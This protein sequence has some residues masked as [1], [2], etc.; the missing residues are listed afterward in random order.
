MVE[1]N[2]NVND[3]VRYD[4]IGLYDRYGIMRYFPLQGPS[5][6][7]LWL[8]FDGRIGY[9]PVG[10]TNGSAWDVPISDIEN[11]SRVGSE[12]L[13]WCPQARASCSL[14]ANFA[15]KRRLI[16]FTGIAKFMSKGESLI[17]QIPGVHHVGAA[18]V[19]IKSDV[20]NRG[21]KARGQAALE[22][23]LKILDGSVAASDYPRLIQP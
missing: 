1:P 10:W 17:S 15:G 19:G 9:A 8:T 16:H 20:E 14:E 5:F 11:V 3:L 12:I 22:A 2:V 6:G 4:R 21:S 18:I 7:D 23:W 13:P